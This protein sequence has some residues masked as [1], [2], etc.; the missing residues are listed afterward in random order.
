MKIIHQ[1]KT[2][3]DKIVQKFIEKYFDIDSCFDA[4]WIG[5][6]FYVFEVNDFYFNFSVAVFCLDNDVPEEKLFDWYYKS[7]SQE[8]D[9][10][11]KH[12]LE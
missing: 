8:I 2:L 6:D 1:W 5:D 12:F 7:V 4:Q 3:S 9:L 10:S 11:L